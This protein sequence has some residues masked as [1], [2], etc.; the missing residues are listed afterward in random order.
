MI[1]IAPAVKA[2]LLASSAVTTLV[3]ARVY[4]ARMP[5]RDRLPGPTLVMTTWPI[6]AQQGSE[7]ATGIEEHRLQLDAYADTPDE[8]DTL[9]AAASACLASSKANAGE[10]TAAGVRVQKISETGGAGAPVDEQDTRIGRR[11]QTFRISAA[12]AA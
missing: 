7:G 9:M 8:A 11:M 3:G 5:T 10:R 12:R 2:L 1:V 4:N 6:A